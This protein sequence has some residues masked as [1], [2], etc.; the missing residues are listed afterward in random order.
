VKYVAP[1]FAVAFVF[2]GGILIYVHKPLDLDPEASSVWG[3]ILLGVG[4]GI[5]AVWQGVRYR[6]NRTPDDPGRIIR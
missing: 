4:F 5:A 3:G 2:V 1:M 6:R